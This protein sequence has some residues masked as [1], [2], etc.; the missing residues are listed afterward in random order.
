ML[1]SQIL[2][3]TGTVRSVAISLDLRTGIDFTISNQDTLENMVCRTDELRVISHVL[4]AIRHIKP[5]CKESLLEEKFLRKY[6]RDNPHGFVLVVLLVPRTRESSA[7]PFTLI[8][9]RGH[10][11]LAAFP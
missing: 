7:T 11:T 2:P 1:R 6:V 9:G 10:A 3:R 4:C 5:Q 8:S